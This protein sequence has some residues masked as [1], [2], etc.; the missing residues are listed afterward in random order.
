VS[1]RSAVGDRILLA[2]RSAGKLRELRPLFR[3]AGLEVID[4]DEAG[5]AESAAEADV[6]SFETFEENALAKADYFFALSG[7]PTVADDSGLEVDA[8]DGRPGVRSKRW[9]GRADLAGQ[10]LDDANNAKLLGELA[11]VANRAARYVCAAA[12]VADGTRLVRRGEVEGAIALEPSGD[13][14][15]GYDP[16]F[17]AREAGQSFGVLSREEKERISHRGRAFSALLAALRSA[18]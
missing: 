14:G 17:V 5:I 8:L 18:R 4:L 6:E 11:G 9:S 1:E 13:G 15:F 10:A 12:F 2:T 7:L 3:D 16:Y